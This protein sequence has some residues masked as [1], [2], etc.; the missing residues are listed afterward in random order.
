MTLIEL[1]VALLLGLL[2]SAAAIGAFLSNN[3]TQEATQNLSR[4]QENARIAFEIMARDLRQAA[5]NPCS[6]TIEV[7][8]RVNGYNTAARWWANWDRASISRGFIG[9][10]NSAPSGVTTVAGSD[11]LEVMA[12]TAPSALVTDHSPPNIRVNSSTHGISTG[13]LVMVCDNRLAAIFQATVTGA[14]ISHSASGNPGNTNANLGIAIGAGTPTAFVFNDNAVLSRLSAARWYVA[15]NG[16]GGN[17]LFRRSLRGGSPA[18]E[19]VEEVVEGVRD[20]QLQFLL[21]NTTNYTDTVAATRWGEVQAVR[22]Q[23]TFE[24]EGRVGTD[25]QQILRRLH[26]T[27][28]LRNRTL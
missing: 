6:N 15:P 10:N 1:M 23:L 13:D 3:R 27:I 5:G 22:V 9:Y 12:A 8:N 17:S 2:V 25:G 7:T 21:P 26:H 4:M 20:M 28:V 24:S 14:V 19:V 11:M 18:G 16:R